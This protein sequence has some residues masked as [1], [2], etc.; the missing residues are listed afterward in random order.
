M[1][2]KISPTRQELLRLKKRLSLAR[3]GHKLLKHK[4]E[5]LLR[6]FLSHVEEIQKLQKRLDEK[7]PEVFFSFFEGQIQL[8]EKETE[9]ILS[10]I[11]K[12]E[13]AEKEANIMGVKVKEYSILN[14]EAIKNTP[15]S[16][17]SSNEKLSFVKKEFSSYLYNDIIKYAT[18]ERKIRKLAEEIEST[19]RRV[20]SLEHV[21]IPA[22]E[23]SR[24]YIYNKLEE[25]ERFERTV[26]MKLKDFSSKT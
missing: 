3:S 2:L 18:L 9:N 11:E 10:H 20:N 4:M 19:R 12:G 26:L 23:S 13:L 16:A 8:G 17:K 24:K 22:M 1:D 21:Y 6:E 15:V 7:L 14:E 25:N 5:S